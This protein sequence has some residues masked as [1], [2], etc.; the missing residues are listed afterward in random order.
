MLMNAA[1]LSFITDIDEIVFAAMVPR[2]VKNWIGRL[3]ALP[4][5]P[6]RTRTVRW[7]RSAPCD[8]A[9]A[10]RAMVPQR[11][12]RGVPVRSV[13]VLL[14]IMVQLSPIRDVMRTADVE[15]C[16]GATSFSHDESVRLYE[17]LSNNV[18]MAEL[19]RRERETL[20][21][22]VH[23]ECTSADLEARGQ[24]A[25]AEVLRDATGD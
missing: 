8:G 14:F 11:T 6:Q 18:T 23:E 16:G 13:V 25:W 7:C 22:L 5:V 21:D 2:R 4:M 9:A 3:D 20:T 17:A 10:H 12:V 19:L 1:A 15:L 24:E